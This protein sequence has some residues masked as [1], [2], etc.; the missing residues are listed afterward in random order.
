MAEQDRLRGHPVHDSQGRALSALLCG[1]TGSAALVL[2]IAPGR[3]ADN[4]PATILVRA[5]VAMSICWIAG[6]RAG[7][8]VNRA[9]HADSTSVCDEVSGKCGDSDDSLQAKES[10]VEAREHREACEGSGL[11]LVCGHGRLL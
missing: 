6:F 4:A 10:V 9:V 2:V 3:W 7:W 1:L 8:L 5:L 11:I